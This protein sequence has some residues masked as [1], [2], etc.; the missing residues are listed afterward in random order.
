MHAVR[1]G[2]PAFDKV[3]GQ[4]FFDFLSTH[5]ELG[6]LFDFQMTALYEREVDAVLNAY[7]FAGAG[8]ILDVGGGRGS[9]AR[10]LVAR[11]SDLKCGL[12]DLPAVADR[13]RESFA[14]DGLSD[15]CTVEAG[16]FFDAIPSGYDTYLLKHVLHDWDDAKC[17]IIL[18]NVRRTIG[19][20]GRLLVLECVVPSG[21]GP[22]VTKESDLLMLALLAGKER[23]EA[24]FQSLLAKTGFEL[25][26]VV[27]TASLLNVLE[28]R[29][30]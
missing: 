25:V 7:D 26:R 28:A 13:A 2:T 19:S 12:F 20:D 14:A 6:Q 8:R 27:H 11:F 16:S 10:A 17:V 9:V 5:K 4:P 23:T 18:S 15:R 3:F 24:E 1:T 30:A 21:N 22:S 29:P